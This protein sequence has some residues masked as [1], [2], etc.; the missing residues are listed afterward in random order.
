MEI[1]LNQ[2]GMY[3]NNFLNIKI[4]GINKQQKKNQILIFLHIE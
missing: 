1:Y 3:L 2:P 4:L